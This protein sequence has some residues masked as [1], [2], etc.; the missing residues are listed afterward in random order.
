MVMRDHHVA[1]VGWKASESRA[2]GPLTALLHEGRLTVVV[3]DERFVLR[4]GD[5]AKL[6]AGR[7]SYDPAKKELEVRGVLPSFA[8]IEAFEAAV[9]ADYKAELTKIEDASKSA[10]KE[11]PAK[12]EGKKGKGK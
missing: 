11:K 5:V 12:V 1:V 2:H 7:M 10:S 9:D 8:V 3:V 6:D 4:Q